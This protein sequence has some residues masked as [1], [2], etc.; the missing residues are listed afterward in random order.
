MWMNNAVRDW[1]K[2]TRKFAITWALPTIKEAMRNL[3][4]LRERDWV[5]VSVNEMDCENQDKMCNILE[6]SK[7]GVTIRK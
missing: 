5:R 2:N 3:R 4:P 6:K 7:R 1:G